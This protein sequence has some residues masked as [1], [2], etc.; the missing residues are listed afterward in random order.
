MYNIHLLSIITLT[1]LIILINCLCR[2]IDID[3]QFFLSSYANWGRQVKTDPI[4][5]YFPTK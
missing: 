5:L 1:V 3:Q 2:L 4:P